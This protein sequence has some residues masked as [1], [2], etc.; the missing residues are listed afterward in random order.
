MVGKPL[1]HQAVLSRYRDILAA[2][3]GTTPKQLTLPTGIPSTLGSL[4]SFGQWSLECHA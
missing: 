4:F 1:E 2:T 3:I